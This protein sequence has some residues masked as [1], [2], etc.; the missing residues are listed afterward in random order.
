VCVLWWTLSGSTSLTEAVSCNFDL[1]YLPCRL[2]P[3]RYYLW[4]GGSL[5]RTGTLFS[6]KSSIRSM[7]KCKT[8]VG[9]RTSLLENC[10]C[11]LYNFSAFSFRASRHFLYFEIK[12][13]S[14]FCKKS[15]LNTTSCRSWHQTFTFEMSSTHARI[16]CSI[17][18]ASFDSWDY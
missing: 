7:W 4:L 1:V 11:F 6:L 17:P 9:W 5:E 18:L 13:P 3:P 10:I 15:F 2:Y 12:F 8:E 16:L 14:V